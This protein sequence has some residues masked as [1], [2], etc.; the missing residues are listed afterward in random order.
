MHP[1]ILRAGV[2][3]VLLSACAASEVSEPSSQLASQERG[4]AAADREA[5]LALHNTA[6][7][8]AALGQMDGSAGKLSSAANMNALLWDPALE[9][10]AQLYAD[11]C[12]FQH[13]PGRTTQ[14]QAFQSG[15]TF[16]GN[17]SVGENL[18]WGTGSAFSASD[19]AQLWIDEASLY[20]ESP[21]SAP[22]FQDYGHFTQVAWASTRY[23][24]CGIAECIS[25]DGGTV[26]YVVCNYASA[27]N[28]LGQRPWTSGAPCSACEG[29]R[30]ICIDG[31]C[32]GCP[33]PRFHEGPGNT[34]AAASCV[35]VPRACT[36]D[37]EC[38][39]KDRCGTDPGTGAALRL[40]GFCGRSGHCEIRVEACTKGCTAGRCDGA[41]LPDAGTLPDAGPGLDGVT[42]NQSTTPPTS[43]CACTSGASSALFLAAIGL[44]TRLFQ[45]Q[46]TR[47]R[48]NRTK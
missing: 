41:P 44:L 19:L 36:S 9:Q 31:L 47:P 4:I 34:A 2:L 30:S 8:A 35:D 45:R 37:T 27:G 7:S 11:S 13:N 26:R 21:I 3:A 42:P 5:L 15:A 22:Q 1:G 39:D 17:V 25:G 6:R 40:D 32:H 14:F 10:V 16:S 38:D 24:G 43:S 23:V 20:D 28:F 33:D 29:D 46:R 48:P 18:A 12:V